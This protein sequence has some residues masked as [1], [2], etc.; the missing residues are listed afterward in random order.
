MG[1]TEFARHEISVV[2]SLSMHGVVPS[3]VGAAAV[4]AELPDT[5]SPSWESAWIDIGGEG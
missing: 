2:S 1:H 3:E 5:Y 4:T